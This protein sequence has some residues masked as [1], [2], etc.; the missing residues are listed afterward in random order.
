MVFF[1]YGVLTNLHY[2]NIH[3]F[4]NTDSLGILSKLR[5]N[6]FYEK[7]HKLRD[8][9]E[10]KILG[11]ICGFFQYSVLGSDSINILPHI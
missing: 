4:W 9:K 5:K 11:K 10:K 7:L 3:D 1:I 8:L 6:S 2:V